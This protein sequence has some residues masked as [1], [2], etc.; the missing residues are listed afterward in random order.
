MRKKLV[1]LRGNLCLPLDKAVLDLLGIQADA[2]VE[3]TTDGLRLIIAPLR[4]PVVTHRDAAEDP[5]TSFDVLTELRDAYA[6]KP[7]HFQALHHLAHASIPTHLAYCGND[8]RRFNSANNIAVARRLI[9]CRRLLASGS[10][11][12]VA[13]GAAL[14]LYPKG[15]LTSESRLS[16]QGAR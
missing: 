14:A 8:K 3:V 15:R 11:W 4:A 2:E 6:M 1:R 16:N 12:E 13:I 9:E 5:K 7:R 10:S